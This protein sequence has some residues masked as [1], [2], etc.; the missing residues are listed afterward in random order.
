MCGLVVGMCVCFSCKD[1]SEILCKTER[2]N[3]TYAQQKTSIKQHPTVKSN[4]W[5]KN[6]KRRRR[7]TKRERHTHTYEPLCSERTQPSRSKKHSYWCTDQFS[8]TRFLRSPEARL[9]HR[10]LQENL[11]SADLVGCTFNCDDSITTTCP[12]GNR[13]IIDDDIR[14]S[15][16]ANLLNFCSTRSDDRSDQFIG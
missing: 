2:R 15:C 3:K 11:G 9:S 4:E 13:L 7:K 12:I 10:L 8:V 6:K 14:L 16:L 5:I 1:L